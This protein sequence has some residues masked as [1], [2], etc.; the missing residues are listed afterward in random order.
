MLFF[1]RIL[2]GDDLAAVDRDYE[3][4]NSDCDSIATYSSGELTRFTRLIVELGYL[5]GI[6]FIEDNT[7]TGSV[8]GIIVI[9][10]KLI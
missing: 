1:S 10:T 6:C 5:G 9:N 8:M 7:R 4:D 2:T 3:S